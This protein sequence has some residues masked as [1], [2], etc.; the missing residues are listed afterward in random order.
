M[1]DH[2]EINSREIIS[3][4][5]NESREPQSSS[6]SKVSERTVRLWLTPVILATWEDEVRRIM[7]QSQPG[8]IVLLTPTSKMT[9]ANGAESVAHTVKP[10]SPELKPQSHL[11]PPKRRKSLRVVYT[12]P[13][14]NC[15]GEV[16]LILLMP[17][18][19]LSKVLVQIT[20]LTIKITNLCSK[21]LLTPTL[22]MLLF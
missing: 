19:H 5:A 9:R 17:S 21:H 1:A 10:G 13:L 20:W 7:V 16:V 12:L 4:V 11:P 18:R 15:A 6:H 2:G 3:K 14:W 8:K 22:H